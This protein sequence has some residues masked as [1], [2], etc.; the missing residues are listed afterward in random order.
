MS[1]ALY[2]DGRFK[3]HG[4]PNETY[5]PVL[6]VK[7]LGDEDFIFLSELRDALAALPSKEPTNGQ[8]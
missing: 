5:E 2:L 8:S 3:N 6:V 7:V 4:K 1:L